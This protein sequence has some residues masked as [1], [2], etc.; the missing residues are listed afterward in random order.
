MGECGDEEM[1]LSAMLHRHAL[2]T[3]NSLGEKLSQE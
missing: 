3:Q 2:Q 1:R